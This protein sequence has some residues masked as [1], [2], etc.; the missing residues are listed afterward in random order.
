MTKIRKHATPAQLDQ[1][2]CNQVRHA[3]GMNVP[4]QSISIAMMF[5]IL[6][7]NSLFG[8]RGPDKHTKEFNEL[9]HEV[10]SNARAERAEWELKQR[11]LE[12]R[13]RERDAARDAAPR[14]IVPG[15]GGYGKN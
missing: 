14:I 10:M 6:I 2:I 12:K 13:E 5:S 9:L 3:Q 7:G 8:A 1:A 11:E 4:A 15:G